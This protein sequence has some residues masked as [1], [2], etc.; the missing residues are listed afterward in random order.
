M[1]DLTEPSHSGGPRPV[2]AVGGQQRLRLDRVAERGAGAVGLDRVHVGRPSGRRWPA[3]ARMTRCWDGPFG[4]VRPLLAPSWLTALPRTTASTWWPVAGAR[5]TAAPAAAARALGQAG[6]VGRRRER[7]APAVRRPARAAGENST[8]HAGRGHHRHAAGQR[9]RALARRA[10]PGTARCS[11]TSEDE[12]AVS[13]VTAGPS[14]PKRVGHPAGQRRWRRCRSAGS[15]PAPAAGRGRA[16]AGG[17]WRRR[18][19]RCRLPRSDAGSMPARSS[20]SQATSS[21]SRCCGSI[22]SASRGLIPKNPASN[23]PASSTN[24]PCRDV[25]TCPGGPGRGRRAAPGPS[26]GR[27][28]TPEIAS[29]PSASSSHSSSGRAHAAGE[30]AAHA[31]DRD[32]L[33]VA[34]RRRR[35]PAGAAARP[36]AEQPA[37]RRCAGERRRGRVVE[38]QRGGQPQPGRRRPAGC[39]AR[40]RSASRSPSSLN[41]RPASTRRRTAWPSTAAAWARTSSSSD[42]VR[43]R[44]RAAPASRRRQRRRRRAARPPAVRGRAGPGCAAAAAAARR[45]AARAA[46]PGPAGPGPAAASSGA[47][48]ASN[49]ARPSSA[50]SGRDARRAHPGQV[51][52]A[53]AAGHAAASAPT[54]PRPAT[55]RAGRR[56]A[57]A[58][59]ARPGTRWPPRSCPARRRRARRPP[60]RTARTPT[61]PGPAVSSCRCQRRVDLGRQHRVHPLRRS[62]TRPRRRRAP[63]RRAPPRVSGRPRDL[64]EHAGQGRRGRRRRRPRPRTRGARARPARPGSSRRAGRAGRAG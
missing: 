51:G 39:A 36:R 20:A 56:P 6:A 17:R 18:T 41:A 8:K 9:Q 21:S 14:R 10:A 50:D 22:A 11:A 19:R 45:A 44:P 63:R 60:R 1:F 5:P 42:P 62:A 25:A 61:G 3:P 38:D 33:V 13:T 53:Q 31:D 64:G 16:V 35:R 57:G 24:P 23:S 47:S 49:S 48:A 29:R 46:R 4:A 30:P 54:G 59:P 2:L 12:H 7:L 55:A 58:R 32:R 52:V 15:P 37:P 26:P 40:P 28:G 34:P 27:P 43:A